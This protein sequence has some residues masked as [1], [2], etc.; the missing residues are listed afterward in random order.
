MFRLHGHMT[1]GRSFKAKSYLYI[2]IY[3]YIYMCVCVC[4]CV[5]FCFVGFYG[6][7]NIVGYLM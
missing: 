4:V 3:I 1:N 2:Y 5:Y 7:S 6:I